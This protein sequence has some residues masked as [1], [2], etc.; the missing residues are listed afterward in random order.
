VTVR[1]VGTLD[2]AALARLAAAVERAVGQR[3]ARAR[4]ELGHGAGAASVVLAAHPARTGPVAEAFVAERERPGTY[5]L[6]SYDGGGAPVAVPLLAPPRPAAAETAARLERLLDALREAVGRLG[7]GPALDEFDEGTTAVEREV[8]DVS[9]VTTRSEQARA[10]LELRRA[11]RRALVEE[12]DRIGPLFGGDVQ[13]LALHYLDLNKAYLYRQRQRFGSGIPGAG[14]SPAQV[15]QLENLRRLTLAPAQALQLRRQLLEY[16]AGSIRAGVGRM[17]VHFD[18]K[19]KPLTFEPYPGAVSWERL[20]E[21]DDRLAALVEA[22]AK[23]VPEIYLL[24]QHRGGLESFAEADPAARPGVLDHALR[25]LDAHIEDAREKLGTGDLDWRDLIPLHAAL[26]RG[27]RSASGLDWSLPYHR[28][29]V[30]ELLRDHQDKEFWKQL[31][32]DVLAGAAFLFAEIATGGAATVFLLAGF[33]IGGYQLAQ[34]WEKAAALE[35]ARG[36]TATEEHALVTQEQVLAADEAALLTTVFVVSSMLEAAT[37]R[38]AKLLVAE[39]LPRLAKRVT[40]KPEILPEYSSK[41][42][43][44]DAMRRRLLAQRAAGKP[45]PLDFLLTP[46]GKWRTGSFVSKSGKQ[47]RGRYALSAPDSPLVQ[48]SHMQSDWYAKAAG[49]REYLMFED[50]DLNWLSGGNVETKGAIANK[51][52]V[53]IDGY[54]VDIPTARVYESAGE[55]APGTVD[56]APLILPPEL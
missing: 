24:L 39:E 29:I 36:A 25:E 55:L 4:R 12:I 31:G 17:E 21:Y 7:I 3:L 11:A 23:A 8:V 26:F 40:L 38:A 20:K 30:S 47:M 18:P 32:L 51:P 13:H 49:K 56:A 52:A 1:L 44:M 53:L 48:A 16:P 14:R 54:P 9:G 2:D 46:D 19:G 28:R 50:A 22:R 6:P 42:S 34:V 35:A 43:F 37:S 27:V 41:Q 15:Q 45:S 33:G 10:D 5:Q